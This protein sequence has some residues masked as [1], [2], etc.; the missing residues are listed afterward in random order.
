M[1]LTKAQACVKVPT[2]ASILTRMRIRVTLMLRWLPPATGHCE[3]VGQG[4]ARE[5]GGLDLLVLQVRCLKRLVTRGKLKTRG[6][7]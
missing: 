7:L 6:L 4:E 1:R 3:L 2:R 5:N